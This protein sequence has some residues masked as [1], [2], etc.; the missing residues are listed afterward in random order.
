MIIGPDIATMSCASP[1]DA[2]ATLAKIRLHSRRGKLPNFAEVPGAARSFR[3]AAFGHPFDHV[4]TGVVTPSATGSLIAFSLRMARRVP[5]IMGA[6][7]LVTIWPG[8]WLTDSML[9]TYFSGYEF[10]TW[11]WYIPVTVLPIPFMWRTW[12]TRSVREAT[13][14]A[15]ES[16]AEIA[17]C[18]HQSAP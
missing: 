3:I 4:L 18:L 10:A 13:E 6:I 15:A 5:L 9:T 2:V 17:A 8:V 12:H 16:I 11:M 1:L 7:V 14:H